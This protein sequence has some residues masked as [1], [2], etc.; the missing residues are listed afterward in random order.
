MERKKIAD[1]L[2]YSLLQARF[3]DLRAQL[4]SVLP[5]NFLIITRITIQL[6]IDLV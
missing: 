1:I 6:E 4:I 3:S 5:W 2:A